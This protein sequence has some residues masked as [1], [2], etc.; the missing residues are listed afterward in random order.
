ML[1]LLPLHHVLPLAGALMAPLFAGST[2]VFATS[3]AGPELVATLQR[4]AVTTI[5]GV[6]RFYDL[7]ARAL[8]ERIMASGVAR[9]LFALAGRV[10]SR[11]F[12]RLVFGTVHRKMGGTPR[13]PDQRRSGARPAD[14][15]RLRRARLPGL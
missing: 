4:N 6:P 2:I 7:L 15:A 13:A 3:L 11:R 14:R 8:R 5:V 9:A 1:L 10:G 12:S